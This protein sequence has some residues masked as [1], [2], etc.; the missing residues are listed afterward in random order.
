MSQNHWINFSKGCCLLLF[1]QPYLHHWNENSGRKWHLKW[2]GLQQQ[3][4]LK[5]LSERKLQES[6]IKKF[7]I[8]QSHLLLFVFSQEDVSF[9]TC[10]QFIRWGDVLLLSQSRSK[11]TQLFYIN[12]RI[13]LSHVATKK[14]SCKLCHLIDKL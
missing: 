14:S 3:E 2:P 12:A 4:H 7:I 9:E 5:L 1:V 10:Y 13:S 6:W 11:K 8:F